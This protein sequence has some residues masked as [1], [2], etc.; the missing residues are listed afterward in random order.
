MIPT[1][2]TITRRRHLVTICLRAALFLFAAWVAYAAAGLCGQFLQQTFA[3]G[4]AA[5]LPSGANIL[6][7]SGPEILLVVVLFLLE[8]RI[9]RWIVPLPPRHSGCPKCG[10]SL[11][12][13]KSPVCPECGTN[14]RSP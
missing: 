8:S 3:F 5:A 1:F 14:L 11:K 4:L 13:L 7:F 10:Y 2:D 6:A 12:D 9:V